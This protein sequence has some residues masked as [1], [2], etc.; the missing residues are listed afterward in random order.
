MPKVLVI[1]GSKSDEPVYKEIMHGLKK[2]GID[3]ELRIS[4]AIGLLRSLIL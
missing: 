2:E 1:F 4:S 3:A